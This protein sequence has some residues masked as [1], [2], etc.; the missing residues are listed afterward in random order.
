MKS[1]MSGTNHELFKVYSGSTLL[2]TGSG[3]ADGEVHIMEQCLTS[4]TNNQY[5]LEC[6]D[7]LGNA[8][9]RD[10]YLTIFGKH[11]NAVFKSV[12]TN[13][14]RKTHAVSLYYGIEQDA[15]WKMTSG[16]ITNGWTAYSFSDSTWSEGTLGSDTLSSMSVSGT[17]YFRKQFVGLSD[18]AAYDVRLLYKAGVIAY[19]NGVEV[20]RD[21]MPA[22]MITSSTAATGEYPELAYRG[23][24]R[25]G[26]EVASQQSILAV[27]IHFFTPQTT[28]DFNAY[29]AILASS[30][31][32]DNCL[33]NADSSRIQSSVDG[34]LR[35]VMNKISVKS[36]PSDLEYES[37]LYRLVMGINVYIPAPTYKNTIDMFFMGE[38]SYLPAG[39]SLNY[40][41][42]EITGV[43]TEMSSL[44]SY[45]IYGKN[46]DGVAMTT[47]TI[48]VEQARCMAEGLFPTS[49]VGASYLMTNCS[50][51]GDYEGEIRRVCVLGESNGV[52][53]IV[54]ECK[55][56]SRESG[57]MQSSTTIIIIIACIVV[58]LIVLC[59]CI[60]ACYKH[61]KNARGSETNSTKQL[62]I[63][64]KDN[65]V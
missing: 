47:I 56:I 35:G 60:I 33:I 36:V 51:K 30:T 49:E 32:R 15:T 55:P 46:Q 25:P 21:N 9:S 28:V 58:F 11:G 48:L 63:K 17:Q 61:K 4:T 13:M 41:T 14:N 43:P 34:H 10:S 64:N 59:I 37:S 50:L 40:K 5:Y 2:Y 20:Y 7:S 57:E 27:E 12:S 23:F 38:G 16:S 62:P 1:G 24:I 45:T 65:P 22:G 52:W 8:W 6:L 29:L 19:I 18:M 3:F 26:S 44:K 53:Q 39:L 42:G 54:G 31:N